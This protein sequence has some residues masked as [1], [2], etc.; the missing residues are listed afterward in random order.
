MGSVIGL[1]VISCGCGPK[2]DSNER[3]NA[4]RIP[5]TAPAKEDPVASQPSSPSPQDA[6]A[7][8]AGGRT[9]SSDLHLEVFI[10]GEAGGKRE[11]IGRT[12]SGGL[13][14]IPRC[15]S[16]GVWP[17]SRI[18]VNAL[19]REIAA[20]KIPH[21]RIDHWATDGDLAHL[22]GLTGL[23]RLNLEGMKITDE[24]L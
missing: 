7:L 12:P 16:W 15:A 14:S 17:I 24:G 8:V 20:K 2:E 1:L 21:L 22:K 6:K 10:S 23:R 13:L 4:A 9:F 11:L 19:A 3:T 18:D 5:N